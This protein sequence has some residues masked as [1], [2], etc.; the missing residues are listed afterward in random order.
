MVDGICGPSTLAAMRR[1]GFANGRE[2]DAAVEA[3]L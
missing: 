1:R 3:P 2:I